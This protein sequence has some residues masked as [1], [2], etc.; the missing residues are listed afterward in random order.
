MYHVFEHMY[1]YSIAKIAKDH[2]LHNHSESVKALRM[3][4]HKF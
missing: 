3:F 2:V 1:A 4:G